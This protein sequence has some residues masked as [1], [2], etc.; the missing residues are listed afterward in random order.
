MHAH[1]Q[2]VRARSCLLLRL[3]GQ[4]FYPDLCQWF[5]GRAG[6]ATS[7]GTYVKYHD[8]DRRYHDL[9]S[10]QYV[11][12][13]LPSEEDDD[14]LGA[15]EAGAVERSD[16]AVRHEL[17]NELTC[18]ICM[19]LFSEPVTVMNCMHTFCRACLQAAL[20]TSRTCPLCKGAL[21]SMRDTRSSP[22]MTNL[23]AAVQRR[24]HTEIR[25]P[26]SQ[27]PSHH[28]DQ[29]TASRERS[30]TTV[31]SDASAGHSGRVTPDGAQATLGERALGAS[32]LTGAHA[33]EAQRAGLGESARDSETVHA[34]A[35]CAALAVLRGSV[36]P[37]SSAPAS[38]A[39][40]ASASSASSAAASAASAASASCSAASA[41]SAASAGASQSEASTMSQADDAR[42]I[43]RSLPSE[44]PAAAP[45]LL[46]DGGTCSARLHA[47]ARKM[48]K[49]F[50]GHGDSHHASDDL[51]ARLAASSSPPESL[52]SHTVSVAMQRAVAAKAA[53]TAAAEA[54]ALAQAAADKAMAR[55]QT[56]V[57]AERRETAAPR[58]P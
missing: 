6:L 40:V 54:A 5:V 44:V 10:M 15:V 27:P 38:A 46:A 22:A 19:S 33:D 3:G 41:A 39:S 45:H 29:P 18:A 55:A 28:Q 9:S 21:I 56:L 26:P 30:V 47:N 7:R 17:M 12:L 36:A 32:A 14:A 13:Q 52:V 57:Q 53:A 8:G 1:V 23:V 20:P 42:L 31:H 49:R 37:A 16:A 25:I 35:A 4:I 51:S 11:V 48:P 2:I 50:H 24:T 34:T 58:T 43:P